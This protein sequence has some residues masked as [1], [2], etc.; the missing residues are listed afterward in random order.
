MTRVDPKQVDAL[1]EAPEPAAGGAAPAATAPGG[2]ATPSVDTGGAPA[3]RPAT[4]SI[5]DFGRL[6][7]RVARIVAAE[8]VAGSDKL[9]QLT[10]DVGDGR[11][12]TVFAGIKAWHAPQ[13]LVGRLTVVVANLAPRKMKFGVSEGM[14]LAASAPDDGGGVFLLEPQAGAA[15]GMRVK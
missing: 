3:D 8:A 13:A 4:I 1:F 15:P 12:R 5:D 7:L 14:V 10:L 6:D 2:A 9:L 11:L